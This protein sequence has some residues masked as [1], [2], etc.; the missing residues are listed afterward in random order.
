M[1][2]SVKS[3]FDSAFDVASEELEKLKS[4]LES[5]K[6]TISIDEKNN[7]LEEDK[8]NLMFKLAEMAIEKRAELPEE[9]K[10]LA[11]KIY[12]LH[13]EQAE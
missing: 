7:K 11:E 6:N 3:K 8:Y 12:N 9:L 13:N 10:E 5:V 1:S 2:E 4:T